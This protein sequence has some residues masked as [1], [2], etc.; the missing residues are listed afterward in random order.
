[1]DDQRSETCDE[2]VSQSTNEGARRWMDESEED[3]GRAAHDRG[4][5]HAARRC[6]HQQPALL[7]IHRRRRCDR[8]CIRRVIYPF[9]FCCTRPV[10]AYPCVALSHGRHGFRPLR[11]SS[12][13]VVA[14]PCKVHL[15]PLPLS[16]LPLPGHHYYM[17]CGFSGPRP[18]L[19]LRS[20]ATSIPSLLLSFRCI[21]FPPL[22]CGIVLVPILSLPLFRL[23]L[24]PCGVF[25][26]L[27]LPTFVA[28]AMFRYVLRGFARCFNSFR[29]SCYAARRQLTRI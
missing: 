24:L 8:C 19:A 3:E 6:A 12:F 18:V 1:M 11:C 15:W 21:P 16:F 2:W 7:R 27:L 28:I 4:G 5:T 23:L 9:C 22:C 14:R 10:I 20:I 17:L 13:A 26:A 25:Y 29:F